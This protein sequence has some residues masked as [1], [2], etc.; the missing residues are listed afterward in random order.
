MSHPLLDTV[1]LLLVR[2]TVTVVV[3]DPWM[4]V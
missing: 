2:S 4:S 3:V 1:V